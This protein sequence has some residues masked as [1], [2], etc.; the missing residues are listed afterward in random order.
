V[1]HDFL[2]LKQKIKIMAQKKVDSNIDI[3]LAKK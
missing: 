1:Q 2:L 3:K